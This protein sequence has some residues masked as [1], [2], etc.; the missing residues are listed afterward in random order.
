MTP[1]SPEVHPHLK[2]MPASLEGKAKPS[3]HDRPKLRGVLHQWAAF[4]AIVAGG[5]LTSYADTP[6]QAFGAGVFAL[7]VVIMFSVSATYHRVVW[8]PSAYLL[9]KRL[10]HAAIGVLIAGTYTPV[11]LE[12]LPPGEGKTLLAIAWTGAALVMLRAAFWPK[13][14]KWLNVGLYFM[15][16]GCVVPYWSEI[17]DALTTQELTFLLT[18]AV[19]YVLGAFAY[20]TKKPDPFPTIFGY[21]EIFHACTIIAAVLHGGMIFT[22]IHAST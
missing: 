18:G 15:L 1:P 20:A 10:D 22:M 14:P 19:V 5:I 9:M 3:V 12:A 13:S 7:S 17:R 4:G 11:C 6:H 21:H 2:K 8:G 16:G